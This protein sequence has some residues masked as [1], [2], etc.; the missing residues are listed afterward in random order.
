[1]FL[2]YLTTR[3]I[4]CHFFVCDFFFFSH[5]MK[6]MV[7]IYF[8]VGM[9]RSQTELSPGTLFAQQRRNYTCFVFSLF[10]EIPVGAGRHCALEFSLCVCVYAC[11]WV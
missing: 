4:H 1:M 7:Y 9:P 8:A 3:L 6:F 5:S 2:F 10:A 11:V